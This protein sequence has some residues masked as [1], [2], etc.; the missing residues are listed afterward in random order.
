MVATDVQ[1]ERRGRR[2]FPTDRKLLCLVNEMN[3][4]DFWSATVCNISREGLELFSS[5]PFKR[6]LRLRIHIIDMETGKRLTKYGKVAYSIMADSVGWEVGIEVQAAFREQEL[7][8]LTALP[9]DA[10]G[11]DLQCNSILR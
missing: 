4:V 9:I 5:S 3:H 10:A 1:Q 11:A 2:R 6:G 7:N 8:D